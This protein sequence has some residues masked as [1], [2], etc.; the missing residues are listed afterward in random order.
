MSY[1]RKRRKMLQNEMHGMRNRTFIK[2]KKETILF[3]FVIMV[4]DTD[5]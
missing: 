3:D 4:V 5:P 1:V 2:Q